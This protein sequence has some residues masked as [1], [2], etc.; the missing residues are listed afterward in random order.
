MVRRSSEQAGSPPKPRAAW[1]REPLV[2]F[3]VLALLLFGIHAVAVGDTRETIRVDAAT[4]AALVKRKADLLLRPLTAAEEAAEVDAFVEE[5]MLWREARRR[6][7]DDNGWFRRQLA[8]NMRGLLVGTVTP[9]GEAEARA[10]FANHPTLFERPARLDIEHV[11][12]PV[13]DAVPSDTM[14]RLK[15]EADGHRIGDIDLPVGTRR[16]TAD[17]ERLI[18]LLGSTAAGAI[19][20]VTDDAWHGPI[21]GDRGV[22]FIRILKRHPAH[23]PSFEAVRPW[24]E[25]MWT[26][27][28]Q[29]VNL[30]RALAEMQPHYRIVVDPQ[31][32]DRPSP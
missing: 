16:F 31:P 25:T 6:G 14:A 20:S 11:F 30:D 12:F 15:Q 26:M 2:H 13:A 32:A 1:L 9:P 28:Q 23:T 29:R 22:Y 4:R 27:Q 24:V 17:R 10:F 21:R 5:E 3:T 19:L 18:G 8:Q 7:L